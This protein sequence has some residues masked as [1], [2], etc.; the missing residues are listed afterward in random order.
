[1]TS[2]VLIA[3]VV[4]MS[5]GG[6][7]TVQYGSRDAEA[8]LQRLEPIPG[9]A[10][11]YVC[12]ENAAFVGAGN[13]TSVIVD[14]KPIGTLKPNNFAHTV[15]E[16]GSHDI[17]LD[18]SPGGKSGTLTINTIADEVAIVWAGMTGNGWGVLTVDEFSD[19]AEAER[20][21]RGAKYAVPPT[22]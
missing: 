20:C 17:Y 13:R 11:L 8:D 9:K 5:L 12:R 2:N 18:Q 21:V 7:A 4:S 16:P 3:A 6:C 15:V 14:D 1:M 22:N 19:R 10:S